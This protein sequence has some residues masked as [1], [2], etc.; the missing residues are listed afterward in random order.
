M[1]RMTQIVGSLGLLSFLT[2]YP[3]LSLFSVEVEPSNTNRASLAVQDSLNLSYDDKTDLVDLSSL[4]YSVR[5]VTVA[6]M[7]AHA[8]NWEVTK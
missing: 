5:T 4:N 1:S 3:N 6:S 8:T 7:S 2:I